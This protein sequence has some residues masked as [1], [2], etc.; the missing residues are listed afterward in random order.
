MKSLMKFLIVSAAAMLSMV[1]CQKENQC[2]EKE[3]MREV[4]EIA[5]VSPDDA[6]TKAIGDGTKVKEVYYAAFVDGVPVHSLENK[7]QLVNG[8]LVMP[9]GARGVKAVIFD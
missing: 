2:T 1:S 9:A 7:V 6:L 5:L 8:R 4:V 3:E